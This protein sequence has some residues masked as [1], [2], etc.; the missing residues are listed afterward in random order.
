MMT[1]QQEERLVAAVEAIATALTGIDDTH[2]K[3]FAKQWPEPKVPREAI[4]SRIPNEEDRLREQHGGADESLE[5]WFDLG[6][7]EATG[8][9]EREFLGRETAGAQTGAVDG[10]DGCSTETPEGEA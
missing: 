6:Q 3:Q 2:Q 9:R 5:Q 8:P 1:A 4:F 7:E 10:P